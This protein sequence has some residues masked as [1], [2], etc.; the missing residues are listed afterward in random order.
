MATVR[1]GTELFHP[2]PVEGF[3]VKVLP[4][5]G[6]HFLYLPGLPC[7]RPADDGQIDGAI[8]LHGLKAPLT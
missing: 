7:R 1:K 5:N 3:W 4:I 8:P 2:E 6:F